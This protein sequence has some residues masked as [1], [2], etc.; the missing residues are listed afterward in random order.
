MA[1]AQLGGMKKLEGESPQ[2][3]DVL[4]LEGALSVLMLEGESPQSV[5]VGGREPSD[6][7]GRC[8][9]DRA[10]DAD[11]EDDAVVGPVGS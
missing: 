10:P 5:D 1:K 11:P 6:I 2:C 3:V 7:R 4:M 8:P 9:G